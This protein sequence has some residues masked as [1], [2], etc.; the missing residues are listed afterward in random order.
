MPESLLRSHP[1]WVVALDVFVVWL[2]A[3]RFAAV[4]GNRLA[5]PEFEYWNG[6][7]R[8]DL[9]GLGAAVAALIILSFALGILLW[10]TY[11]AGAHVEGNMS[12]RVIVKIIAVLAV[13]AVVIGE[14]F[15]TWEGSGSS[16]SIIGGSDFKSFM[17][18]LYFA[19][20]IPL[21]HLAAGYVTAARVC[22]YYGDKEEALAREVSGDDT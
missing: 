19:V 10:D 5:D 11:G 2:L 20:L 1:W 14:P 9:Y 6:F 3:P 16:S 17:E 4:F 7:L 18:S 21:A 15:L 8:M 12:E 13:L 22:L